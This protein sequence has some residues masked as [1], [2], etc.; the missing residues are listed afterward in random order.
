MRTDKKIGIILILTGIC[1]FLLSL[2]FLGY[3]DKDRYGEEN[4]IIYFKYIV[5]ERGLIENI[6][7]LDIVIKKGRWLEYPPGYIPAD[8]PR[9]TPTSPEEYKQYMKENRE[10]ERIWKDFTPHYKGRIAIPFKY[11]LT[12]DIIIIFW[13]IGIIIFSKSNKKE[14]I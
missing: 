12:A 1:L 6:N 9:P 11:F 14:A 8:A 10:H 2:L 4:E 5:A 13:G 3:R 7:E